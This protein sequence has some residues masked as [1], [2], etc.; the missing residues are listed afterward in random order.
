MC[1]LR[2]HKE[3][4]Y[5]RA[6]IDARAAISARE[7]IAYF[8]FFHHTLA[9]STASDSKTRM[10]YFW[11]GYG[12]KYYTQHR[13]KEGHLKHM[14]GGLAFGSYGNLHVLKSYRSLVILL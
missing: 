4:N 3:G 13:D 5:A 9:E 10:R 14:F 12:E 7:R 6:E 8:L 2:V 11:P 1:T